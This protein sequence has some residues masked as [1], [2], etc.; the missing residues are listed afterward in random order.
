MASFALACGLDDERV[1]DVA[2]AVS[3]AATNAIVH[4]YRGGEGTIHV[5]AD[6][7]DGEL[8]VEV[9]DQG[10]GL[11]PRPDSPGLGLGLPLIANVTRRFEV[12]TGEGG[13][14]VRMV[15]ACP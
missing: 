13:T 9:A 11:A 14:R 15:F 2:L 10:G 4:G 7:R 1:Q 8:L 5:T 12:A 6:A 3:E